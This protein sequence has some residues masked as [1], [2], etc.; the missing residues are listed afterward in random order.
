VTAST[1]VSPTTFTYE[2]IFAWTIPGMTEGLIN[3]DHLKR[4]MRLAVHAGYGVDESADDRVC[5]IG[6]R[7]STEGFRGAVWP[8][9]PNPLVQFFM[10]HRLGES[11]G[12]R[13]SPLAGRHGACGIAATF[14]TIVTRRNG[15]SWTVMVDDL[16]QLAM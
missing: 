5:T 13:W 8:S 1:S 4:D 2:R 15:C 7:R 6:K 10:P 16:V 11:T 12:L 14:T 3:N 9:K